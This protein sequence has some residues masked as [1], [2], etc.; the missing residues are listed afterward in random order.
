MS[1]NGRLINIAYEVQDPEKTADFFGGFLG[2]EMAQSLH[3][4]N[5]SY[6]APVSQDGI[7]LSVHRKY[8]ENQQ[9]SKLTAY[10]AVDDLD[11]A[12]NEIE[13]RGGKRL[14]STFDMPVAPSV[15]G[16]YKADY[17]AEF[18]TSDPV[19]PSIG[20]GVEVVT[21]SGENIG[22]V[23]LESHAT[24]YYDHHA[25]LKG[26]AIGR[27]ERSVALGQLLASR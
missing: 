15:F 21:G 20:K 10:F 13:S 18:G 27:H 2:I 22:L 9:G 1:I 11:A 24:K 19:T 7:M 17:E 16:E 6:H 12:V 5:A 3:D 4:G 26:S 8:Q 23:Q 14:G 25:G